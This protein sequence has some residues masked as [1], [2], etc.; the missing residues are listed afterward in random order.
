MEE[1][2]IQELACFHSVDHLLINAIYSLSL[3]IGVCY[4]LTEIHSEKCVF[5]HASP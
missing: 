3:Y 4:L 2:H 5:R 1:M